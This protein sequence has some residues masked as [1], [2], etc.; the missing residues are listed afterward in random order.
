MIELNI[1][2]YGLYDGVHDDKTLEPLGYCLTDEVKDWIKKNNID[3]E[4][5]VSDPLRFP[6]PATLRFINVAEAALFRL[7]WM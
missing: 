2:H 3:C 7:R 6:Y 4:V 5:E 1:E